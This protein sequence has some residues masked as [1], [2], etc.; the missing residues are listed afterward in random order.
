MDEIN[1][2]VF[3]D[4]ETTGLRSCDPPKITELAFVA[5]SRAHLLDPDNEKIPR[6]IF[7]LLLPL[8]PMKMIHPESTR[9]TRNAIPIEYIKLIQ[10]N[11]DF[12]LYSF[13]TVLDNWKLENC[14]KMDA[15]TVEI[16]NCFFNQLNKPICLVAHNGNKFDY[17]I[18]K[19]H[20]KK[21][22]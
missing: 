15:N 1:S 21:L 14:K 11:F 17:P 19:E 6:V 3:F 8:N 4:I 5:C 2:F 18:L 10:M 7:K 20:L 22:V 16:M 9:I 13:K 12:L